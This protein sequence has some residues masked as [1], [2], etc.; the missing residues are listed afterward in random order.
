ME[1]L[2]G[3]C[4]TMSYDNVNWNICNSD[5]TDMGDTNNHAYDSSIESDDSDAIDAIFELSENS[6][7]H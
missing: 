4:I 1:W 3:A 5:L 6:N 2:K 7:C